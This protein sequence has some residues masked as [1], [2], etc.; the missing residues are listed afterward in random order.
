MELDEQ[1]NVCLSTSVEK[2]PSIVSAVDAHEKYAISTP[3]SCINKRERE[4]PLSPKAAIWEVGL[5]GRSAALKTQITWFDS[6]TSHHY[7]Q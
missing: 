2:V 5:R 7:N 3:S 6:G 1:P 4:L